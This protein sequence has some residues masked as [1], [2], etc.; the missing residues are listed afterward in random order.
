MS[1]PPSAWTVILTFSRP[2]TASK[3]VAVAPAYA[4]VMS[5][6]AAA[7]ATAVASVD[8]ILVFMVAPRGR[9]DLDASSVGIC[10]VLGLRAGT[11]L[12]AGPHVI[13]ADCP[14][15]SD[16]R[17][18]FGPRVVSGEPGRG[19]VEVGFDV[20]HGPVAARVA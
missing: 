3:P 12:C 13:A 18:D 7:M 2:P 9:S 11:V 4:L 1:P 8:S 19:W 10:G 15:A 14:T 6:G 16:G 20:A 5:I 17:P